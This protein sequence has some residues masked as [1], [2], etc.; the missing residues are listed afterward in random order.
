[1]L[2][3]GPTLVTVRW[4]GQN[5]NVRTQ[6]L[7]RSLVYL[8]SLHGC[9]LAE[10]RDD[11]WELL[12]AFAESLPGTHLRIGWFQVPSGK[13]DGRAEENYRRGQPL[14]QFDTASP[15]PW[16]K[17]KAS[18]E[19]YQMLMAML[20]VAAH[21]MNLPGCIGGRVGTGVAHLE[22]IQE[23]ETSFLVW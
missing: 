14:A 17:T 12:V 23:A 21:G 16:K 13:S 7:R 3:P 4:Q 1:M 8:S 19:H 22:S 18:D 20:H 11:P 15:G 6:D 9:F 5:V 2:N 10:D